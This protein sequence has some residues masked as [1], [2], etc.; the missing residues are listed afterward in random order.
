MLTPPHEPIKNET[1]TVLD[2]P[3]SSDHSRKETRLE[4]FAD[5]VRNWRTE[6]K[7]TKAAAARR[8]KI[9]YRTFQDWELGTHTPRGIAR[10]AIME[11]LARMK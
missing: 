1:E 7:L 5:L 4:T 3:N 11:K 10:R 6:R 9:P 8:L 2:V